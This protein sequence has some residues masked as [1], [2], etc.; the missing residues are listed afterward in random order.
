MPSSIPSSV[1]TCWGWQGL[2]EL[3]DFPRLFVDKLAFSKCRLLCALRK[4][5][6][7][8]QSSTGLPLPP[9]S[10]SLVRV[11]PCSPGME[12]QESLPQVCGRPGLEGGTGSPVPVGHMAVPG[13]PL[14]P[15]QLHRVPGTQPPSEG[16]LGR[17]GPTWAA[18]LWESEW[19]SLGPHS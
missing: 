5:P 16:A 7:G 10:G 2:A 12:G 17:L 6:P 15:S 3:G 9:S 14:G 13:H 4:V 19:S 1:P 18:R 8:P 11:G